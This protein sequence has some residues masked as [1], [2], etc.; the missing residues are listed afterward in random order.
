MFGKISKH[1][2]FTERLNVPFNNS[3][4]S[5]KDASIANYELTGVVV[6]HGHSTHSGHYI[7]YVKAPNGQWHEM[8]D[9]SVSIASM[10]KV[11]Q[12]QGYL[13]F[14]TRI[15]NPSEIPITP[16]KVE[17]IEEAM[18]LKSV[19]DKT[20][21][22]KV[23]DKVPKGQQTPVKVPATPLISSVPTPA[24]SA[25]KDQEKSTLDDISD[26]S[27]ES[28]DSSYESDDS[29]FDSDDEEESNGK[30]FGGTQ[31]YRIKLPLRFSGPLKKFRRW[32]SKRVLTDLYILGRILKLKALHDNSGRSQDKE[33]DE[34]PSSKASTSDEEIESDSDS[35]SDEMS[36]SSGSND[37][38]DAAVSTSASSAPSQKTGGPT[39]ATGGDVLSAL[40]EQSRRG[41]NIGGEGVWDSV[42]TNEKEKISQLAVQQRRKDQDEKRKTRLSDWD[43]Q[44]DQGRVKKVKTKHETDEETPGE[45]FSPFQK[46]LDERNEQK[47]KY[48]KHMDLR[49]EPT[50]KH[51]RKDS[52][53]H[54]RRDFDQNAQHG[55]KNH[56]KKNNN[57][58]RR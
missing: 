5:N 9:S 53:Q 10:K 58:Q 46:V 47:Q 42:S 25:I 39:N 16:K 34:D 26:K 55:G 15:P 29:T 38:K 1:I 2:E 33:D 30:S 22:K 51:S 13:L 40:L 36:T 17:K 3:G 31:R 4:R 49:E 43:M 32:K 20:I 27:D 37:G 24:R 6:H 11:L 48:G 21:E 50:F 7:A 19:A 56:F 28:E 57:F 35:D 14:Y 45:K 23:E 12:A 18:G 8:N 44:L 52:K 41:R 54:G